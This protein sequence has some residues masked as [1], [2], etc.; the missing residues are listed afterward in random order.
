MPSKVKGHL[1]ETVRAE[2]VLSD[3]M[4]GQVVALKYR[5]EATWQEGLLVGP[6]TTP[7]GATEGFTWRFVTPDDEERDETL[8][9][10][11][12]GATEVC[13]L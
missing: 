11:G 6:L 2:D 10:S 1:G 4:P 7:A 5:R 13:V 8:D 9:G 3:L 12:V